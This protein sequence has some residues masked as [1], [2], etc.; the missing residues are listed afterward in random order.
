[1]VVFAV[2]GADTISKVF[3]V[4]RL[5]RIPLPVAGDWLTLQLVYNPG[6]A[7]GIHVGEYSRWVFTALAVLALA[8]LAV[9]VIRTRPDQRGRL[10][11]LALVVGGALG[12]LVDRLR[13]PRGVVDFIDV[14]VGTLRW[15]TFNIADLAVT[16]GA[17]TLAIMLW[18]EGRESDPAEASPG[19]PAQAST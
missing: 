14:G 3:A 1:L 17:I 16:C 9:M 7:F 11:A 19:D 2:L 15:P 4:S 18:G 12:N 10:T 8:V 13:N 5:S 6:A